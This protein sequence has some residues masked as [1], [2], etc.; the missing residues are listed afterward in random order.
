MKIALTAII[1]FAL[2]LGSI[3][4][5]SLSINRILLASFTDDAIK[6]L[7]RTTKVNTK[8]SYGGIPFIDD[9]ELRMCDEAFD[10]NR[11]RY[12]LRINPR[13]IGETKAG[14]RFDK[15]FSRSF[16]LKLHYRKNEALRNRYI[17]IL[18]QMEQRALEHNSKELI[19]VY[20]DM[21]KVME[22]K[23][24]NIEEFEFK[25]LIDGEDKNTKLHNEIYELK[26]WFFPSSNSI[27]KSLGV[28]ELGV[29]DTAGFVDVDS[30]IALV[31]R[32]N[33]LFDTNNT[34]MAY[35]RSQYETAAARYN[36]EKAEQRRYISLLSVSYD[37]GE[38]LDQI[39]DHD[40]SK[41][42]D[43]DYAYQ[44]EIGIKIPD[45]TM[46]RHDLMRRKA[47]YLDEKE[48]YEQA[49]QELIDQMNKDKE[50]L[51]SFIAQ[52]RFLRARE[53]EVDAN[54]SLKKYMQMSGVDP[55]VLLTLKESIEKNHVEIEKLRY[56]ILRNYIQ[57]MD[58]CGMLSKPPLRNF[59]SRN[60]EVLE[61]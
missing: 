50:D 41:P 15:S 10:I 32:N 9:I 1:G 36:L 57:V 7:E 33:F 8:G 40:R 23:Q 2:L 51:L 54:S 56:R 14:S 13:G 34:Y 17:Q 5:D 24:L 6:E 11:M 29:F 60:L 28:K 38:M 61:P 59:L 4:A 43:Y 47:D 55:L 45:L 53:S 42:Y 48:D 30:V 52:F 44:L 3:R 37:N 49:K 27:R 22:K 46:A 25:D 26:R 20:E 16:E 19:D 18:D 58:Y 31:E 39:Y 21:I 35:F 12:T